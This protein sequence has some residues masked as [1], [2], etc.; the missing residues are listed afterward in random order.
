MTKNL[1][2]GGLAKAARVAR[3][4]DLRRMRSVLK[5]LIAQC[6]T[7]PGRVACPIIESLRGLPR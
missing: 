6:E 5:E 7:A 2:I 4:A 1:T 3:I